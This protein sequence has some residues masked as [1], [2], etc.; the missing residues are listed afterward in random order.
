MWE[1]V[2]LQGNSYQKRVCCEVGTMGKNIVTDECPKLDEIRD[3]MLSDG[4]IFGIIFASLVV[5]EIFGC[6]FCF[7][8]RKRRNS[9]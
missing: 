3:T 9:A 6:Y 2:D 4:A 5:A 7:Y 1:N 8:Y